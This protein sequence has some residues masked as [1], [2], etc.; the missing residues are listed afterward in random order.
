[1]RGL[2]GVNGVV[3]VIPIPFDERE[4]IDEAALRRL[5]EFAVECEVGAI[6]LPAYGSEFYK[7]SD[8]ER[9]GVVR[10]AIDQADGRTLVI[11]QSNHG[12][13]R[14]AADIARANVD[15]GADLI[16]I[17]VPRLFALSDDDLLRFLREVLDAAEVPV[18][19]QD[20][21]PGGPTVSVEFVVRLREECRNL[22]YLKLEEPILAPKVAA[23]REATNDEVG[24]L[25]EWG[26]LYIMELIPVGIC[27]VM[28]GLAMADL[29]NRIF[30]L[31]TQEKSADAFALF[32]FPR[33]NTLR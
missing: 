6:C 3:P 5:I 12:S 30:D 15:A 24:V 21:N 20:F 10:I 31:R 1:M 7:L 2:R 32:Y 9:A 13:S 17:A 29:L 8:E 11:A 14:V 26:G 27:G 22:R 18:L 4:A 33:G 16:S 23:I 28:P 25:E 19:L